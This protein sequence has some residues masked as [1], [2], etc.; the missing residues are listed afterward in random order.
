MAVTKTHPI[1][2]TLKAAIDYICNSAKTDGSLLI[3]SYG[4]SAET[5]DIEFA[6]TRQHAI[7]KGENLGRHLIQ[8]FAPG[9]VTPEEAHQIGLELAK[10]ILGGKYEF[11][12]TTH[13]DRGHIHN[14]VI[15]NAV[16]FAD[17][18][19]YHSNK[20]SYYEIRRTSDRLCKE[21]GLSVIVPGQEKGKSYV[22]HQAVRNGTSY[23]AKLKAAIDRLLPTCTDLEDLLHRLQ[24]EGYEIRRGKYI[25]CRASSQ[26]RF[27]RL[28]T[29]GVDYTEEALAARIAGRPRPS[30]Q[31]R[32]RDDRIQ[33]IAVIQGNQSPGLQHWAKLQK[34]KEGAKTLNYLAEHGIDSYEALGNRLVELNTAV[35]DSLA[36][37]KAVEGRIAELNL[38]TKYAATYRKCRP[39]YT[40]YRKSDDKE[41]FLRGHESEIILFEAAARELKRLGAVPM[42]ATERLEAELS[43]LT[44]RKG[45]LYA[46]YT[47]AKQQVKEYDTIKQNLD[48]LLPP[49]QSITH[50]LE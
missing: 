25:S 42:P 33:R 16:S 8:A 46:Q 41:K 21:H 38:I 40:R 7:D 6:W 22:E 24:E 19:H 39:I 13:I 44:V 35:D 45:T 10:E 37:I 34:L 26:E 1:K 11:I 47:A 30:K 48:I 12:L 14:H 31:P 27:T 28:K 5:A 23:K 15:W 3:S 4:C 17:H 2:S 9:E 32:A 50:E 18:K 49:E 29:L 36:S 43:E 20:R